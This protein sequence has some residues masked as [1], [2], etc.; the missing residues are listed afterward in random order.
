MVESRHLQSGEGF[1]GGYGGYPHGGYGEASDVQD[2]NLLQLERDQ[3]FGSD[4][5]KQ[6]LDAIILKSIS[7]PDATATKVLLS[8]S[9]PCC[10][11]L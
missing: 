11:E 2:A 8:R 5:Q 4:R 3:L 7:H 6:Y 1:D 9:L 10:D